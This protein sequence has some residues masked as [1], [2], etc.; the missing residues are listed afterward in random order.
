[1][2]DM[3]SYDKEYAYK[4][5]PFKWHF[6]D[7]LVSSFRLRSMLQPDTPHWPWIWAA[8]AKVKCG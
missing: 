8:W 1:M 7:I 3:F 6:A 2:L 5:T 4:H